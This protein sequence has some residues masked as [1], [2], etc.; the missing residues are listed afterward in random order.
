MKL[1]KGM[2]K[3]ELSAYE[4]Q[5]VEV[6]LDLCQAADMIKRILDDIKDESENG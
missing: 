1:R 6:L 5:L 3:E 4:A 2:T